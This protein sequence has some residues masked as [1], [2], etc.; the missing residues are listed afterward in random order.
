MK[1]Q[2]GID[3]VMIAVQHYAFAV[4]KRDT[5]HAEGS[6]AYC[7]AEASIIAYGR[8]MVLEELRRIFPAGN[9]TP[10]VAAYKHAMARRA[11]LEA[12]A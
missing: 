2:D 9:Q 6:A 10:I 3:A 12:E 11:E 4:A 7:A 8:R 1:Q 5:T